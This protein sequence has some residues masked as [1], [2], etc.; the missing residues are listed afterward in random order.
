MAFPFV[1]PPP[2]T[3]QTDTKQKTNSTP[4]LFSVPHYAAALTKVMDS[5]NIKHHLN[6][7]L[8]KVDK[9]NR[10]AYFDKKDGEN[11]EKIEVPFDLLNIVPPQKPVPV[12]AKSD[13]SDDTG[14]ISVDKTSMVHTKYPNVFSMGDASNIPTSK[15]AAA[16]FSQV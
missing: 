4:S 13:L 1:P 5:K 8:T 3:K 11:V 12:N 2:L 15:T 6:H 10:I 7:T 14:Y 9:N 16:I